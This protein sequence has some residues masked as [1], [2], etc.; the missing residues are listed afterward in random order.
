MTNERKL[1][2]IVRGLPGSGKSTIAKAMTRGWNYTLPIEVP[3]RNFS[4]VPG[5]CCLKKFYGP[6]A[7]IETDMYFVDTWTGTYAFEQSLIKEAHKWCQDSTN[8]LLW[9]REVRQ[10]IVSNTFC[11]EWEIAPYR[12][13][14]S[15]LGA[16]FQII[17][18]H[19]DLGNVHQVPQEVLDRM[20]EGFEDIRS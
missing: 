14:A 2:T 1:L 16:S 18:V 4:S 10:V 20:K 12:K 19:G 6:V 7:H 11:K 3:F 9:Q 17:T 13:I 8:L 5:S 15:E